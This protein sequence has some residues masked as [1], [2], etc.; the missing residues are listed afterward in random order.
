[1][2]R[3]IQSTRRIA[4]VLLVALSARG[5]VSL[6]LDSEAVFFPTG[7]RAWTIAKFKF[8]GPESPIYAAQGG[9]RHHFANARALESWGRFRDG[10]VIVDERVHASLNDQGVWQEGDLA[11][12]AVMRKDRKRHPD[13]GGWYFNFFTAH[14]TALGITQAQAKARCFEACHQSQASRD[15]VFSDPRR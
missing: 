7:Y 5:V 15:Y 11:H 2:V 4:I 6:A 1:M 12:V 8:V 9:M 3:T 10:S 13:T 14:D